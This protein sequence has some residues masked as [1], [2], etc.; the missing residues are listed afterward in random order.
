[1]VS[2]TQPLLMTLAAPVVLLVLVP[3]SLLFPVPQVSC[4]ILLLHLPLNALVQI[5]WESKWTILLEVAQPTLMVLLCWSSRMWI[6]LSLL[7]QT[8][9]LMVLFLYHF[10]VV[11]KT[12]LKPLKERQIHSLPPVTMV[13]Q[14]LI[15]MLDL[16]PVNWN[17]VVPN[18]N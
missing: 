1:M 16:A 18:L 12:L 15:C 5:F 4:A 13:L 8:S 10:L 9:G 14:R 2:T 3:T 6:L 17:L 11:A 7:S